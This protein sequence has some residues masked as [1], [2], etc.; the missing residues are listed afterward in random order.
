MVGCGRRGGVLSGVVSGSGGGVSGWR[1]R[2]VRSRLGSGVIGRAVRF[3]TA[4]GE[5][6]ILNSQLGTDH[7]NSV[8]F[9]M[10]IRCRLREDSILGNVGGA[11]T[12][13]AVAA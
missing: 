2:G 9:A 10:A 5:G 11:A 8:P 1:I 3:V 12:V 4:D 7:G 13:R 6:D